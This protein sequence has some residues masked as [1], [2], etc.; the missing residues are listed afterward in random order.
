MKGV[1]AIIIIIIT[2][3][4]ILSGKSSPPFT[5]IPLTALHSSHTTYLIRL[6]CVESV[7]AALTFP[8]Y[9][10]SSQPSA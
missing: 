9:Y 10:F 2:V 5:S 4:L 8:Y 3:K 7:Q 6:M 1:E